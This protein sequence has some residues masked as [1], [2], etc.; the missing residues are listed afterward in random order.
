MVTGPSNAFDDEQLDAALLSVLGEPADMAA[1][2]HGKARSASHRLAGS[3]AGSRRASVTLGLAAVGAI[4]GLAFL[5]LSRDEVRDAPHVPAAAPSRAAVAPSIDRSLAS[6]ALAPVA[7]PSVVA[8]STPRPRVSARPAALPAAAAYVPPVARWPAAPDTT[9]TP[10]IALADHRVAAVEAAAIAV[11]APAHAA[12]E[13]MAGLED[14]PGPL[15]VTTEV[16]APDR[17]ARRDS[18]VAIR[19]L[20]RQW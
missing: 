20:R 7:P 2:T 12:P 18:V 8:R 9:P 14:D 13:P 17:R 1:H 11:P 3:L 6:V 19:S 5:P 16:T 4:A 15:P 10:A